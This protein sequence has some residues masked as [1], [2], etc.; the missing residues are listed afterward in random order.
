[1]N[2]NMEDDPGATS[3]QHVAERKLHDVLEA[4]GEDDGR[5]FRGVRVGG[6]HV[7]YGG[8]WLALSRVWKAAHYVQLYLDYLHSPRQDSSSWSTSLQARGLHNHVKYPICF[9]HAAP[10]MLSLPSLP[11]LAPTADPEMYRPR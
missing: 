7:Y 10:N 4:L 11:M 9:L 1:M 3:R 8:D 2:A 5:L 6:R